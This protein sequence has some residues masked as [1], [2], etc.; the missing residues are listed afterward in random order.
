[1]RREPE[2]MTFGAVEPV[3]GQREILPDAPRQPRE[4]PAAA[5]IGEQPDP[6]FGHR[7]L[8]VL[9][10]DAETTRLRD[11][12]PAAHRDPVHERHDRL[13]V[14]EQPVVHAIFGVE[15]GACFGA[16]LR[17]ALGE[18]ADIAPGAKAAAFGV[19]DRDHADRRVVAPCLQRLKHAVAHRAVERVDRFRAIEPDAADAAVGF[20]DQVL[21][22]CRVRSRPTIIRIT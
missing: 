10:R 9:G 15:E 21:G 18:H 4:I 17:P 8:G 2:R 20:D 1:M 14:G 3:P 11:A 16:V 22:H 19:I 5:D 6:G 13:G 12:D 7:E